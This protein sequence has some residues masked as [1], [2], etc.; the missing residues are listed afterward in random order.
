MNDHPPIVPHSPYDLE[1]LENIRAFWGVFYDMLRDMADCPDH[2][3]LSNGKGEQLPHQW[4]LGRI[5]D[6]LLDEN[7]EPRFPIEKWFFFPGLLTAVVTD[8]A[9]EV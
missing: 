7:G 8:P 6:V 1:T 3:M 5:L 4:H 2:F 9:E